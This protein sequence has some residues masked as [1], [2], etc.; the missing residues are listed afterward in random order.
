M[1]SLNLCARPQPGLLHHLLS[2]AYH[3]LSWLRGEDTATEEV[4]EG[5]VSRCAGGERSNA[6][7]FGENKQNCF[8]GVVDCLVRIE[9]AERL[10]PSG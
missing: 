3:D 5:N 4:E 6:S 8:C 10:L 7:D 9:S 2:V 1:A